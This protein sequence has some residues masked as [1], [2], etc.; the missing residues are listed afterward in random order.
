MFLTFRKAVP[1]R[2]A[3]G[4]GSRL[5]ASMEAN[6]GPLSMNML[7]RHGC[8]FI[9]DLPRHAGAVATFVT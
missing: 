3:W 1:T 2:R 6:G 7:P 9:I 4:W 8:I 5:P